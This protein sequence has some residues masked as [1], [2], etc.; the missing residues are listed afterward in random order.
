MASV[1]DASMQTLARLDTALR[2]LAPGDRL[3]MLLHLDEGLTNDDRARALGVRE[4]AYRKRL[5]RARERLAA[6]LEAL[7]EAPR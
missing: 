3:V 5:E 1:D 4:V 7:Q 2:M 6:R